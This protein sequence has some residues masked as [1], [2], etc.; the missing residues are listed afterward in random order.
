MD[1]NRHSGSGV[2]AGVRL[3]REEHAFNGYIHAK[4]IPGASPE[5]IDRLIEQALE[6]EQ[7]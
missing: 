1:G 2:T 5:L 4:A 6:E 3:L 7:E